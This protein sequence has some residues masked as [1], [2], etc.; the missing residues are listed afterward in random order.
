[1]LKLLIVGAGGHAQVVADIA[2]TLARTGKDIELVGFIDDNSS[3]WGKNILGAPVLGPTH[4]FPDSRFDAIIIGIGNNTLRRQL[5]QHWLQMGVEF[6]TLI[7]PSAV[8][9]QNV[10][11]GV[12]TVLCAGAIVNTGSS[13]GNHVILNTACSVDHHNRIGDYVHIAPGAHVGG[14]VHVAEG[15]L[16]G[17][18]AVIMPQRRVAAWATVGAGAVVTRHIEPNQT[19]VGIPARPADVQ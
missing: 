6:A 14:D 18:G 2:L 19:V 11:I 17:I 15:S 9:A 4:M 16:I 10:Q 3:L 8:V 13:I 1:M 12:S 5:A 7:H